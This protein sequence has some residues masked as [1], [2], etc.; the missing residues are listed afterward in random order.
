MEAGCRTFL[1]NRLEDLL[2]YLARDIARPLDDPFEAECVIVQSQGMARYLSLECARQWRICANMSFRFPV[3]FFYDLFRLILPETAREYPFAMET[4]VWELM[5]I[6]PAFAKTADG[7]AV[8][9]YL[10]D[11][12]DL[13]R[14]QLAEKIAYHFDQYLIFRPDM[15]HAWEKGGCLIPDNAH[16]EWQAS[17]WREL[18]ARLGADG[19]RTA[20]IERFLTA[21]SAL[22]TLPHGFPHR[23]SV[24][25]ISSL[26][27]IY[28]RILE[29]LGRHI[30]V[31]IYLLSPCREYWADIVSRKE[32]A[33]LLAK[34]DPRA[35]M[36][37]LETGNDLLASLGHLGR[38]FQDLLIDHGLVEQDTQLFTLPQMDSLLHEVQG[39]ILLMQN[40]SDTDRGDFE[41]DGSLRIASCHSPMREMEALHDHLLDRLENVP[42]L[43]PED[44]VV[45]CPDMGSSAPYIEAVFGARR[46]EPT[47]IPFHIADQTREQEH[48]AVKSFFQILDLTTSRFEASSVLALLDS[49]FFREKCDLTIEDTDAIRT[50]VAGAG[51]SWGPDET[52]KEGLGL[53]GFRENTWVSGIERMLLGLMMPGGIWRNPGDGSLPAEE[54][55]AGIG[56]RTAQGAEDGWGEETIVSF[57][58][59]EGGQAEVLGRFVNYVHTLFAHLEHLTTPRS[60]GAWKDDL[61][62]MITDLM[63]AGDVLAEGLLEL[64]TG[65]EDV[66]ARA[67]KSGFT[68]T[69]DLATVRYLLRTAFADASPGTRFLSGGVTFCTL[70]P[71]RSIPFKVMCLV[72]LNDGAFPRRDSSPGFDLLK[73]APRKGDRSLRMDDRYLFLEA[74]ISARD[75]MYF[76]YVGQDVRDNSELP[77]SV[78]L[79]EVMDYLDRY[80]P[81]EHGTLSDMLTVKHRL[82]GFHPAYF[83]P[84]SSL[85]SYVQENHQGAVKVLQSRISLPFMQNDLPPQEADSR[86]LRLDALLG[87][88]KNP[89]RFL[90]QHRLGISLHTHED[91]LQD[92]EPLE[93]VDSLSSYLLGQ[94]LIR[95]ENEGWEEAYMRTR[96]ANVL[97]PGRMGLQQFTS[98]CGEVE[99]MR[100]R[101]ADIIGQSVLVEP[102]AGTIVCRDHDLQAVLGTV[103]SC[104][105]VLGRFAKAKGKDFLGAWI[106]HLVLQF[107]APSMEM[108]I[109]WMIAKD[110]I[111]R[112]DPM[113]DAMDFLEELLQLADEGENRCLSF[114]PESSHAFAKAYASL[115]NRYSAPSKARSC[116]EGSLY[117]RGEK[118]D[119]YFS[120][121]FRDVEPL[122]KQFE[123]LAVQVFGPILERGRKE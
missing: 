56:S 39:D 58:R 118:E 77:P 89:A 114:F 4:M 28:L 69:M 66:F 8:A 105:Q 115:K 27:P 52:F 5:D 55:G 71:M 7:V 9:R 1:G 122:D 37:A 2:D 51:I 97:P 80:Y 88:W 48:P 70:Q 32:K 93:T 73:A 6:L 107:L 20:L 24:F 17:L 41:I 110:G 90:A 33:R 83:D 111:W 16:E 120:L 15:I 75:E 45:M 82:Q 94:D 87:F 25:G 35:D 29:A 109:T 36:D 121:A 11:G 116:W 68:D 101:I 79:S 23:I 67:E 112:F 49:P 74:L 31:C 92:V 123:I 95:K 30:P 85:T 108:R 57:D 84:A 91:A 119:L 18:T 19:H 13:K 81:V 113:D 26:P 64:T 72:G 59:I 21:L 14:Y 46:G 103:Y 44:V 86:D 47:F 104:G 42:D 43:R 53:P 61:K 102:L 76:S 78:L 106:N 96:G 60:A 50:W 62:T 98:M 65:V 99:A 34:N 3:V 38:H 117:S 54:E 40:P 12:E 100:G 10:A 63:Q 22:D